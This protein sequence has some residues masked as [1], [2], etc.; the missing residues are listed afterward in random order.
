M[1]YLKLIFKNAGFFENKNQNVSISVNQISN[2]LHVLMGERPCATYRDTIFTKQ[3]D[4]YQIANEAYIKIDTPKIK[5]F[6]KTIYRNKEYYQNEFMQTNKNAWNSYKDKGR[7]YISYEILKIFL[8]NDLYQDVLSYFTHELEDINGKTCLEVISEIIE[9]N[10]NNP[11]TIYVNEITKKSKEDKIDGKISFVKVIKDYNGKE[12]QFVVLCKK[13]INKLKTPL[14]KLFIGLEADTAL[15]F[16]RNKYITVTNVRGIEP[17][18]RK[19]DGSLIIEMDDE[20]INKIVNNKGIAK[21]LDGG[22]VFIEDVLDNV[23]YSELEDNNY[24]KINK[25]EEYED[26][27]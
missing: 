21:I 19:I 6:G 7:S 25:L 8:G 3:D 24:I 14:V 17:N 11:F 2:M 10:K 20:Y 23:S 27:N 18:L 26:I 15:N 12:D 5:Q 9:I 16:G 1:S 13:L 4:I 22:F